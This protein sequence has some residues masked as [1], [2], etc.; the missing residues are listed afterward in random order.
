MWNYTLNIFSTARLSLDQ[1]DPND[2]VAV[3]AGN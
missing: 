2:T 1:G 3:D